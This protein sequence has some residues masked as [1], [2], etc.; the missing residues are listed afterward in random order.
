MNQCVIS[1]YVG[2]DPIERQHGMHT[3][4][5]FTVGVNGRGGKTEWFNVSVFAKT[6]KHLAFL[7]NIKKGIP[8]AVCGAVSLNTY[9]K[10]GV[11][12]AS[13]QMISN[14]VFFANSRYSANT[15]DVAPS[16]ETPV[17]PAEQTA[18]QDEGYDPFADEA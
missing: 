16:V 11:K 15:S 13:L 4:V 5:A 6:E 9:E 12:Y 7:R 17:Q 10:N 2:K 18:L 14:E 1:G 3:I 8:I